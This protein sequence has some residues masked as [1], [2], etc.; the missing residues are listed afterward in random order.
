MREI[1]WVRKYYEAFL[2]RIRIFYILIYI[3][4]IDNL[5]FYSDQSIYD[6]CITIIIWICN[7]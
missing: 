6:I 4:M 7:K 5:F 2:A 1:M 3:Y